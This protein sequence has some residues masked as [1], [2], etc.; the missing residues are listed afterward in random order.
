MSMTSTRML[1]WSASFCSSLFRKLI[2]GPIKTASAFCISSFALSWPTAQISASSPMDCAYSFIFVTNKLV[3][4]PELHASKI[5]F[6][7]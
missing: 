3:D 7:G 4:I 2:C 1:Y 5:F 6:N